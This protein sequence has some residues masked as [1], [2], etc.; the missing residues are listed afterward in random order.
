M[1]RLSLAAAVEAGESVTVSYAPSAEEGAQLIRDTAGNGASEITEQAVTNR[2]GNS[3]DRAGGGLPSSTVR[4]I[5]A[6]LAEKAQRTPSQRKVSSRLLDAGRET[7]EPSEGE[8]PRDSTRTDAPKGLVTVDIRADVTPVV[9]ARIRSLGG[10]VVNSVP[11]YRAIRA[12]LPLDALEPLAMLEAVQFIRPAEQPVTRRLLEHS[13]LDQAVVAT[14]KVNTTEGDVAHQANVARQTHSVDATGIGVGVISDGVDMFADQQ[15]TGD[16][17]AQVTV[18]PGQEGGAFNLSCGRRSKGTEGTAMF[19]I[20]HDLAPGAELFFATG[21]GGSAQMAQ[22]IEDLCAAGADV[23]VDDIGYL[24]APAFQDGVIAQA[25]SAAVANGCYY[26]SSA[27]NGGNLNDGRSR[28]W[29]GD[30]AEGTDFEVNGVSVGK[31]HE[32]ESGVTGNRIETDS[33]LPITLQWADPLGGSSN[34]YDLFV[35]DVDNNVL[36]SSTDSQDGTQDPIEY[37]SS[38][39]SADREGALIVIVKNAGAADRY[40][41]LNTGG[42]LAIATSGQIF[43][44]PASQD[45]VG[46]AAVDVADA[47]GAGGVFDGT[48]SVEGFSSDGPRRMFFEAT[49]TPITPGNFS[50]TGGRVLQKPD[51]AA[52]DGVSTSTPGFSRFRGTSAAAPHAAGIAALMVEASGGPVHVTPDEL[53]KAMTGSALDI[54]AMGVDRDSGAG[55]VMA[56]GAVDAVDVAVA[57]RNRAPEVVSELVDRTFAPSADA[58]TIDVA[59]VFDDPNDDVLDY[60]LQLS[61]D[62]PA[63][64]LSGSVLTLTPAGPMPAV[65]VTVRATD[66]GGLTTPQT[67]S[68]TV[69]AGNEDFDGDDDNLIDVS[70]LAQL[71][72]MRY[73][74]NG[75]GFVDGATWQPYYTAFEEAV[76]GMGCPDG[77]V[78]YELAADLDFDTDGSGEADA[79]DDYWN[80]GAGWEPIGDRTNRFEATFEGNRRTITRLFVNRGD[81]SGLFGETGSASLI[82]RLGLVDADVTG[83]DYV[84]GLVGEG[85]G[86]I[87]SCYVTGSV[88][89]DYTVG[90]LIGR[91]AGAVNASY[92]TARVTAREFGGG[93]AG[94]NAGNA[95]IRASYATGRVS[96]ENSGGLVGYN[97]ALVAASYATGRVLGSSGVGGLVGEDAAGQIRSSYWDRDSSGLRVGVGEDD[98]DDD[99]WLEAWESRT[100]GVAG[101]S[102]AALQT[103]RGYDGLYRTWNL[104]LNGDSVVDVPWFFE[105]AGYPILSSLSYAAGG[106]QLFLGPT[107]TAATTAGQAQVVLTWTVLDASRFWVDGPEIT[108]N[109]IRDDGATFELLVEEG[110]GPEY[111]DTDVTVG[112]KYTYQVAA[113]VNGGEATR[114]AVLSVVAGAGNQPPVAVGTLADR[115]LRVGGSAVSVDIRGSVR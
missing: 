98:L 107:L 37:I 55:I 18:L 102:T 15:A 1:V 29:E 108:Y 43:G 70:T 104:D 65:V 42:R 84:G 62:D 114:S 81:F 78:G 83:E 24:L 31:A 112:T 66:P 87:R 2:T 51:L 90:G 111:T 103:P 67:F 40:L 77:C 17:P 20:V 73:D 49:G 50:S 85:A 60:T 100:P 63:V 14:S 4:Q 113:V 86:E 45:A 72:A 110:D 23:I 36:S 26:F 7:W 89:G 38:P 27:G 75:D 58:V 5:E 19:E 95:W 6:R 92:A 32:F 11:K 22:N 34:D 9:L 10:I 106:Y 3:G 25:V 82:R 30:Y 21:N 96:G 28:V 53:R 101:L 105:T 69:T 64:T 61:R 39:C 80:A 48:E 99:G 74:L 68:V 16:V 94:Q 35:I 12:R 46:V 91:N 109:V 56:P 33:I 52:A 54:E 71:D 8:P 88:S 44:H 115:T 59:D 57:D 97:S 79:G 41:R 13:A 76:L 47:G 93:L